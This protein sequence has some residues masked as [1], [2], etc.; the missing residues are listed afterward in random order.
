MTHTVMMHDLFD[1]LERNYQIN[2]RASKSNSTFLKRLRQRFVGYTVQGCTA[3]AISHYIADMQRAGRKAPTINR[4]LAAL[5]SAFRTGY[6]HDLVTRVPTIK[7]L[8]ELS[9]R[10]EFFT[11][12]EIDKLIP[13]LPVYLRDVVLFAVLT[14]WRRGEIVSLQWS[15]VSRSGA[16][17]RLEPDQNKGRTV[18]VL[19]LQGKLAA[20][21]ER[22]WHARK[23]GQ[24][25]TPH[26]F[27]QDGHPLGDFR[28]SWLTACREAGLGHRWFH[29]LRRSAARNMSLQGVPEKVIMSIMGHKTRAMFDRYNIITESD[30]REYAKRLFGP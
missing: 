9:V 5:R 11:P 15:N 4:E 19:A 27:H 21:I 26:V 10:N 1:L 17:I 2:N 22:R 16:V 28:R 6:Q 24:T 25:L 30:Q 14:G 12:E 23:V 29:S 7:R 13:H 3:L 18:R 8:P 20:L